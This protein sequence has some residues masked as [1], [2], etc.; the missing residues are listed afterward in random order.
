MVCRDLSKKLLREVLQ[1]SGH[2][3]FLE[4]KESPLKTTLHVAVASTPRMLYPCAS[5]PS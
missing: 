4:G 1:I 2:S 5:E 3:K